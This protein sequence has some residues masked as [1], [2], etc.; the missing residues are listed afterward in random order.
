[1]QF[2]FIVEGRPVTWQR[3]REYQGR[4]ITDAK[5]REA[6]KRLGFLALR[7]RPT[8]WPLDAL[9]SIDVLGVWPDRKLGDADRL[10]SLVMDAL[11]GVAYVKD[12]QVRRQ[13]GR[14]EVD[15]SHPRTEITVAVITAGVE[16]SR[17]EAHEVALCGTE[18]P[19]VVPAGGRVTKR[20]TGANGGPRR[21][22]SAK[23]V[24]PRL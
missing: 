11:E 5:Q 20:Q 23:G 18:T 22:M 1:M 16:R 21:G 12:R 15:K 3:T 4:R 2:A 24:P 14:M 19:G 13:S 10:T 6:K 9:Y 8:G 17:A 7:A